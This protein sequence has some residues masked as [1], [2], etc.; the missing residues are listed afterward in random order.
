VI[1]IP[2][3]ELPVLE[4]QIT[5]TQFEPASASGVDYAT[6]P[7]IEAGRE[8]FFRDILSVGSNANVVISAEIE[9][10]ESNRES[11]RGNKGL[12]ESDFLCRRLLLRVVPRTDLLSFPG[13]STRHGV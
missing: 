7:S 8:S 11:G 6:Y 4:F 10:V 2:G 13:S 1:F 5:R 9:C 12:S 3:G